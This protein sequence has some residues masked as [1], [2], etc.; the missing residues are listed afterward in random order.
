M[1]DKKTDTASHNLLL[2]GREAMVAT[3]VEDVES[4]D[5]DMIV[6]YTY[7][8]KMTLKGAELK[9]SCLSVEE[10]RLEVTGIL[11]SVEYSDSH[12]GDKRGMWGKIF[13]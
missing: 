2:K 5:E 4:F 10:G 13:R 1:E 11:D 3:G 7:D 12:G 8:G 6:A 9:I